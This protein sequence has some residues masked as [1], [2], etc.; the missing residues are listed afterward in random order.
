MKK[1]GFAVKDGGMAT[2]N[3]GVLVGLIQFGVLSLA[4]IAVLFE[5]SIRNMEELP[6]SDFGAKIRAGVITSV[7]IGV[8]ALVIGAAALTIH[9]GSLL[10]METP[11]SGP[12]NPLALPTGWAAGIAAML[13]AIGS[14]IGTGGAV[15][16]SSAGFY[17]KSY[18]RF[19]KVGFHDEES[20]D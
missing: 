10:I 12:A 16:A 11:N 3:V 1:Y 7:S 15:L 13:M 4:A 19:E 6:V 20:E 2:E 8:V 14:I 17:Y 5:I 9:I 18:E